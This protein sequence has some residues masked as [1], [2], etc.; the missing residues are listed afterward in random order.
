MENDISVKPLIWKWYI[1]MI[2]I[3][4]ILNDIYKNYIFSV[5]LPKTALFLSLFLG[6]IG[7]EMNKPWKSNKTW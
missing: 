2:Y 5:L 3:W 4:Y 7:M 1:E 6:H